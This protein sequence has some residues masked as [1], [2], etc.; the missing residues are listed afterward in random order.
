MVKLLLP[1]VPQLSVKVDVE[2]GNIVA[3]RGSEDCAETVGNIIRC[4]Q[5]GF[6][7]G[8]DDGK[9]LL[10]RCRELFLL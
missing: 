2:D 1:E 8:A 7:D 3:R 5:L 10:L 4:I 9:I 6:K